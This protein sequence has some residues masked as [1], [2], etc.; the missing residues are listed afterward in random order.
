MTARQKTARAP[1]L[2]LCTHRHLSVPK[3]IREP[4]P[5]DG[6]MHSTKNGEI[7]QR[8]F[9][10]KNIPTWSMWT[11]TCVLSKQYWQQ[12]TGK[13]V[14]PHCCT[15]CGAQGQVPCPQPRNA[16]LWINLVSFSSCVFIDGPTFCRSWT[17]CQSTTMR[18]Q[19]VSRGVP[20]SPMAV[21]VAHGS[22]RYGT[23]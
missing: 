6:L 4:R 9:V 17:V 22:G 19:M 3:S 1:T 7:E 20:R 21:A 23:L 15:L 5:F 16:V 18:W 14:V 10:Q 11:G 2:Q 8:R 13:E 12:V